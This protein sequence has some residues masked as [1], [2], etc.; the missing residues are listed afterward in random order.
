MSTARNV[1]K[2]Q[3]MMQLTGSVVAEFLIAEH[4]DKST[5][6]FEQLTKIAVKSFEDDL[7]SALYMLQ[8]FPVS[9]R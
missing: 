3:T 5:E 2:A 7:R 9:E 6:E 4:G 1:R 8:N